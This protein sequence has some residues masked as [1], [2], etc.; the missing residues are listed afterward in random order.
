MSRA[1]PSQAKS[2]RLEARITE[3]QKSLIERAAA[4][5]GRSVSDFVVSTVQEAAKN[6]VLEHELLQLNATQSRA[7]VET[8]LQPPQ[9]NKALR[10]AASEYRED[11]T[12]R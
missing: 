4:Y 5:S 3:E 1:Y 7:F 6:L 9:P 10:Q 11:V 8:L 2:A 12:S